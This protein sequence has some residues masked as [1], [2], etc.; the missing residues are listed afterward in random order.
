MTRATRPELTIRRATLDDL[1]DIVAIER[2]SFPSPWEAWYFRAEIS[3]PRNRLYLVAIL[4]GTLVGYIGCRYVLEHCHIGTLGVAETWRRRGIAHGLL[5]ALLGWARE[6]H[7]RRVTLEYRIRNYPAA[8]LYE[9]VGFEQLKLRLGY[10]DDTGEDALE[11]TLEDLNSQ[12]WGERL[13]QQQAA[14]RKRYN[15][16][17][18]LII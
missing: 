12:K 8:R 15:Y 14:W 17:L 18:E 2:V 4:E 3:S 11:A 13:T 5:L 1:A 16:E 6:S 9:K 7:V 10:Y